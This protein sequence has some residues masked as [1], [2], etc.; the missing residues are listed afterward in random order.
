MKLFKKCAF[1]LLAFIIFGLI[2]FVFLQFFWNDW[3]GFI[4]YGV[5]FGLVELIYYYVNKKTKFLTNTKNKIILIASVVIILFIL[6]G[7]LFGIADYMI[8]KNGK[9]PIFSKQKVTWAEGQNET[10]AAV[11]F[12]LGYKL[13][14]CNVCEKDRSLYVMPFGIGEY[15]YE[16][17]NCNEKQDSYQYI[18]LG[19]K[20]KSI[21]QKNIIT[22]NNITILNAED[23]KNYENEINE[24]NNITGCGSEFTKNNDNTYTV[25]KWCDLSELSK[26]DI[27]KL[28]PHEKDQ[29]E[30]TRKELVKLY[31]KN[32]E[33][34]ECELYKM[35]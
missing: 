2:Y 29:L 30:L 6:F 7:I 14:V 19:G 28:Y 18:F 22:Y 25:E 20:L 11:Y 9:K 35:R 1:H 32:N 10:T 27:Q 21:S 8:A 13:V 23:E 5:I 4:F 31:K 15:P 24:F 33:N 17:L 34:M 26:D 16:Y 3:C 12:G